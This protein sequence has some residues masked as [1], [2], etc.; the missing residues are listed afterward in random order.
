MKI[1]RLIGILSILL[2]ADK[3]TAPYLAEKFEV[4]RRTINRDIEHLCMSGIPLVTMQGANGGITIADGYKID[5]MLLTSDDMQAILSG[6]QSLDSISNTNKYRLLMDK[7]SSPKQSAYSPKD[8]IYI[9]L[10]S[11]YKDSLAPKIILIQKAIDKR[12]YLTFHYCGPRGESLRT[13]EPYL[14]VFQWASWYVWGYCTKRADYRLFKL[15]RLWDLTLSQDTH[16]L[17]NVPEY[18]SPLMTAYPEN[19]H[20]TLLLSPCAK[21][22][23]IE[24]YGKDCYTYAE[25]GRLLFGCCF[26]TKEM[27][28]DWILGY[29]IMAE[30]IAPEEVRR[31]FAC[32]VQ[33]IADIYNET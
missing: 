15:N 31:E 23:L 7:I 1:D 6:L 19:F 21:W 9:D 29:G 13:I 12:K 24:E 14:I 26:A 22:K 28:M 3:V 11:Y 27:M 5:K 2:Q 33:N 4:S 8:H 20:V 10:A 30:V 18:H 25:D 17:R 16:T 32:L